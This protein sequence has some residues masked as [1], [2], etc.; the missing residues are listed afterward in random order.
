MCARAEIGGTQYFDRAAEV[1]KGVNSRSSGLFSA[2]AHL[3]LITHIF[4]SGRSSGRWSARAEIAN[5]RI[6]IFSS[7][8]F[9]S[10]LGFFLVF[11]K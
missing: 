7:D 9:L 10:E 3:S 1:L 8:R 2:R 4:C 11:Y 5:F 6:R